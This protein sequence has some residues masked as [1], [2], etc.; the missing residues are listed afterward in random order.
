MNWQIWVPFQFLNFRL[1]PPNL[2][3]A[4]AN[5]IALVWNVYLSW[6]SHN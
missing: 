5:V 3:V 4:A 6:A 1:V 2:Q